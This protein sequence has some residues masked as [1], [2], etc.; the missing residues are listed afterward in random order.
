MSRKY[1]EQFKQDAVNLIREKGYTIKEVC[2]RLGV[3]NPTVIP[4]RKTE[5]EVKPFFKRV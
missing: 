3:T 5:I 2:E 4:P 1:S